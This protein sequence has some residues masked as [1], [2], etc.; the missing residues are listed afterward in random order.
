MAEITEGYYVGFDVFEFGL[1][2]WRRLPKDTYVGFDVF[3]FGLCLAEITEGYYVGFD[4][5]EF[6]LYV[7]RRLPKDNYVGFDVFEFGLYDAVAVFNI[8]RKATLLTYDKL[9]ISRGKYTIDGCVK[10]KESR[11]YHAQYKNLSES[12]IA[13]K[14]IRG[15]KKRNIDKLSNKEGKTYGCG[16][17]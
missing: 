15:N 16:E 2:V 9:K 4:V 5:F 13:R 7:W 17:F 1:Y 3:E 11:F 10:Q 8:G 6:G 12:K 14:I